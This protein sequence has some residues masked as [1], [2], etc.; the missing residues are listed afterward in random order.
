MALDIEYIRS[1]EFER[2]GAEEELL[3]DRLGVLAEVMAGGVEN[4]GK[5]LSAVNSLATYVRDICTSPLLT[6]RQERAMFARYNYLKYRASQ[7][8][9]E[10]DVVR[11]SARLL[12][13]IKRA[14]HEAEQLKNQLIRCNLRLVVSSARKHTRYD[15]QMMEMISEG[16]LALLNSVEKFDYSRG[17][18]FS[19][20]ATWAIVRQ[21]AGYWGKVQNQAAINMSDEMLEIARDLRMVDSRVLE[22]ES[23][24]RSLEEV[25]ADTL[26]Q[27]EHYIVTEHYGLTDERRV[28]EQRK[29]RSLSQIG[30]ILGISKERVRQVELIALQKLRKAMTVPQFEALVGG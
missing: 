5:S 13:D 25:M 20:Y 1:A 28:P 10:I 21:F 27:R 30:E 8:Q 24:R 16:N 29:G 15:N 26:E 18:R 14:L 22:V 7:W 17:V 19:T 11:P 6:A 3:T 12:A 9:R 23:A 2:E 4:K